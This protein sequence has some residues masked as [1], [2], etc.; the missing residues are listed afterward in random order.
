VKDHSST[1]ATSEAIKGCFA[2]M[3]LQLKQMDPQEY[4][5]HL[6]AKFAITYCSGVNY[7][8]V[9]YSEQNEGISLMEY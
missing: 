3:L 6:A 5:T 8:Q 1:T 2:D 7:L 4:F 9:M